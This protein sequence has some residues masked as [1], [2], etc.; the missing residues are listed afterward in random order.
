MSAMLLQDLLVGLGG[1]RIDINVEGG[2]RVELLRMTDDSRGTP[3]R[4]E[5]EIKERIIENH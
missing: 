5:C 4:T 3:N 1:G 2:G